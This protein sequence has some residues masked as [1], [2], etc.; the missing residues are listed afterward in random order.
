MK[1]Q[2]SKKLINEYRIKIGL[3][4]N[5]FVLK[6]KGL[7]SLNYLLFVINETAVASSN[8]FF[9]TNIKKKMIRVQ[10]KI[11]KEVMYKRKFSYLLYHYKIPYR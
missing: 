2:V 7:F 8:F 5:F 9:K 4:L 1:V 6:S 11:S 3:Y 10:R